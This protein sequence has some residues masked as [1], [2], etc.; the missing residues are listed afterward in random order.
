[1]IRNCRFLH[2]IEALIAL[3]SRAKFIR[4]NMP[5][6]VNHPWP[7]SQPLTS[8]GSNSVDPSPTTARGM[9]TENPS[10]RLL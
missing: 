8:G 1:M 6:V 4:A 7:S 9:S 5:P 3:K 2:Q 10:N